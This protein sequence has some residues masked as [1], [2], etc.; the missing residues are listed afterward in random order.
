VVFDVDDPERIP[1]PLAQ[2]IAETYP[3][4]QSSR[5]AQPGRGHYVFSQPPGRMLGNSTGRLG[6]GWGEVR[7]RNGVIIAAPSRHAREADGARYEWLQTG[8]VPELPAYM[9]E[10][11]P[12]STSTE[13][14]VTDAEVDAFVAGHTDAL[15][16]ECAAGP[17][18]KFAELIA[19]GGSRESRHE[20]AVKI[21][22]WAA[23]EALVGLYDAATSFKTLEQVFVA[24]MTKG[25]PE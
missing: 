19:E 8:D 6:G 15:R 18:T 24:A 25:R 1:E 2:A 5:P 7:G 21:A 3:P 14:A 16:P 4:H 13:D 10:L 23:R 9:A 22:A 17:L 11:L 12:D 20:T